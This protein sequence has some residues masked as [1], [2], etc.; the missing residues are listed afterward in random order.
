MTELDCA[1]N[2]PQSQTSYTFPAQKCLTCKHASSW[3]RRREPLKEKSP[4]RIQYSAS[5][6]AARIQ[7]LVPC[8][9]AA[10]DLLCR[11]G[12]RK[13]FRMRSISLPANGFSMVLDYSQGMSPITLLIDRD[14]T[15]TS[16]IIVK[17]IY[18]VDCQK[19]PAAAAATP[20]NI[21]CTRCVPTKRTRSRS[22][23]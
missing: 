21:Y 23:E 5:T 7:Q 18:C 11:R 12:S 13:C 3:K 16:A 15:L 22:I 10:E 2:L 9:T 4:L 8:S 19:D 1:R 14:G 17:S 6:S 20:T